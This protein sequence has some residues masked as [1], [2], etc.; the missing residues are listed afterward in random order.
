[1][2]A[3]L[4]PVQKYLLRLVL[5]GIGKT[6]LH[7]NA[8]CEV[9]ETH[10]QI[11][12][13]RPLI[14]GNLGES[15]VSPFW[16]PRPINKKQFKVA[17]MWRSRRHRT[18]MR[19][20]FGVWSADSAEGLIIVPLPQSN[21]LSVEEAKRLVHELGY[22]A[23]AAFTSIPRPMAYTR[24]DRRRFG[25][26]KTKSGRWVN[27]TN[28]GQPIPYVAAPTRHTTQGFFSRD[29][30]LQAAARMRTSDKMRMAVV[31]VVFRRQSPTKI[32]EKY[33]LNLETLKKYSTRIRQRIPRDA[34][35][36]EKSN[37]IRVFEVEL[38]T[39]LT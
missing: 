9:V 37:K 27:S 22:D 17:R 39:L 10:N 26:V 21:V 23:R 24:R 32:A 33:R 14:N 16:V 31:E 13:L 6:V 11:R 25:V 28:F 30:V 29:A 20:L 19:P 38:S 1:M 34:E 2:T 12:R 36:S 7:K 4:N 5:F 3:A 18:L 8:I 15:N 35:N